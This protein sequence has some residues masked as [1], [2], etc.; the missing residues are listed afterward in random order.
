[1]NTKDVFLNI[2][3][4]ASYIG[5]NKWDFTTPFTRLWKRADKATYN[6]LISEC[7]EEIEETK[8]QL[9]HVD[10]Q[11]QEL[12]NMLDCKQITKRQFALKAKPFLQEQDNLKETINKKETKLDKV[13]LAPNQIVEKHLDEANLKLIKE[14]TGTTSE[15]Q[16]QMKQVLSEKGLQSL[17]KDVEGYINRSHGVRLEDSAVK[18]FER[19]MNVELDVSQKFNK[20]LLRTG[21]TTSFNWYVCGKVDGLYIDYSNYSNSYI[22]EVKNRT[23]SFFTSL[24]DYEKTQIQLYMW[25]LGIPHAKLVEKYDNK[26]RI[27]DISYDK[28]YIEEIISD[29]IYFSELFENNFLNSSNQNK[30]DFIKLDDTQKQ[31]F[32]H[33]LYLS[34]I[35][36]RKFDLMNEMDDSDDIDCLVEDD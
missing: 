5:Q 31:H 30:L 26:I 7:S 9:K 15:K 4:I 34:K 28:S 32:L 16:E 12:Q 29:L 20:K 18:M 13:H 14:G 35:S 11:I 36:Q 1:M 3:D 6:S 23:K 22:V 33:N 21:N 10:V 17:E 25:M 8:Q 24:R 27:T 2:S 19:K